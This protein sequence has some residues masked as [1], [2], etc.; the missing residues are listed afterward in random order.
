M[1]TSENYECPHTIN[2]FHEEADQVAEVLRRFGEEPVVIRNPDHFDMEAAWKDITTRL[3]NRVLF[4]VFVGHGIQTKLGLTAKI[5]DKKPFDMENKCL[6]L[7][8]H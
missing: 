2:Q 7:S 3:E 5:K 4:F 6:E 8:A 1:R